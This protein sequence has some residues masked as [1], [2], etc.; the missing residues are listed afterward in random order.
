MLATSRKD[1]VNGRTII[2]TVSTRTRKG[3]NQSGAPPGKIPAKKV[4]IEN[5]AE[6][7]I[8]ASHSGRASAKVKN[9][10][11]DTLNTQGSRPVKFV[12][13]RIINTVDKIE[14]RPL[15]FAPNVRET[16]SIITDFGKARICDKRDGCSHKEAEISN[17][18]EKFEAQKIGVGK[19]V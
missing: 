18:I 15:R 7:K 14:V 16:C 8:R 6:E 10:C 3:F 17:R 2:L 4:V 12:E 11:L 1:R 13:I 9:R 19:V 5:E